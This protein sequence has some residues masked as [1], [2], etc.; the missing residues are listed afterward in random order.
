MD[1]M[2]Q[3]YEIET[4]NEMM[5]VDKLQHISGEFEPRFI[6]ELAN[7]VFVVGSNVV[8]GDIH[9]LIVSL[10]EDFNRIRSYDL[11]SNLELSQ[12]YAVKRELMTGEGMIECE[13][14]EIVLKYTDTTVCITD[15]NMIPSPTRTHTQQQP[16]P[17]CNISR[18]L[19]RFYIKQ[20]E[21]D[22]YKYTKIHVARVHMDESLQPYTQ[23]VYHDTDE[24]KK[25]E[26]KTNIALNRAQS[27]MIMDAAN[28][29]DIKSGTP[30][31]IMGASK[32]VN[33]IMSRTK[34]A[35][36]QTQLGGIN[37]LRSD[38]PSQTTVNTADTVANTIMGTRA[39]NSRN[40]AAVLV[41]GNEQIPLQSSNTSKISLN[42]I[43]STGSTGSMRINNN[44]SVEIDAN[45]AMVPA[46]TIVNNPSLIITPASKKSKT[47]A[48]NKLVT[49]VKDIAGKFTN[50]ITGN[51]PQKKAAI[52]PVSENLSV[53][54]NKIASEALAETPVPSSNT[55]KPNS[56]AYNL[57]E[58]KIGASV[59]ASPI[60]INKSYSAANIASRQ[61]NPFTTP[62]GQTITEIISLQNPFAS[63]NATATAT[64]SR[65][66]SK[67]NRS[68]YRDFY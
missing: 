32:L 21:G 68:N 9:A 30:A 49:A 53:M 36:A 34:N 43:G 31:D 35:A 8:G 48:A 25:I 27:G 51:N 4:E 64:A 58:A 11:K 67:T 3:D 65:K 19:I 13:N 7:F 6:N 42:N 1:P 39:A 14:C 54:S 52:V 55:T 47:S 33:S 50:F 29:G 15:E 5:P 28:R 10:L 20:K 40:I 46:N 37:L 61:S 60:S 16:S 22:N 41:P 38:I 59:H 2:H 62:T 12:Y 45:L 26:E 63:A 57:M 56:T 17:E 18:G 44:P 23:D 24:I 66:P